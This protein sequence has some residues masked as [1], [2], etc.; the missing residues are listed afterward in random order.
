MSWQSIDAA[1]RDGSYF[2]AWDGEAMRV[3]NWPPGCYPGHWR[4][5]DGRYASEWNG[6]GSTDSLYAWC[7]LP[8]A[9]SES[10]LASLVASTCE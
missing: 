6:S 8:E 1:P 7:E 4:R 2:L 3:V 10:L 5:G 9:P